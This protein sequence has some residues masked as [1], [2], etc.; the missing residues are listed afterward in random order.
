MSFVDNTRIDLSWRNFLSSEFGTQFERGVPLS[1]EMSKFPDHTV[2]GRWKEASTANNS[3]IRPVELI[4]YRLVTDGQT[5]DNKHRASA[6]SRGNKAK[7]S[8][9]DGTE[10]TQ[11]VF[12]CCKNVC[13]DW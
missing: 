12:I 5:H 10:D 11:P 4:Q 3:S 6:A 13:N 9:D 2:W 1:L 8:K 7:D